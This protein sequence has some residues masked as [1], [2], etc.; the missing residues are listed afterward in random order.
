MKENVPMRYPIR[1]QNR[2]G[3]GFTLVEL[4][5]VIAIIGILIALLLPAVQAARE[6]ARRA[7]CMS[8]MKQLGLAMQTFADGNRGLPPITL[9]TARAS[10]FA[11][12]YPYIE[13]RQLWDL[14]VSTAQ[15][16]TW[17]S[18]DA[19]SWFKLDDA[20]WNGA[21][22]DAQRSG[23]AGVPIYMCPSRRTSQIANTTDYIRGP[24][25]DYAAV[26]RYIY[27]ND[28]TLNP[29]RWVEF[30]TTSQNI[31]RH[32]GALRT[33]VRT[34]GSIQSWR[35][36]DGMER[37]LDGT[38]NTVVFG[39]KHIPSSNV[40]VCGGSS[41]ETWDCSYLCAQ[42][43]YNS[44]SRNFQVGRSIHFVQP[45]PIARGSND[46]ADRTTYPHPGRYNYYAFGSSHPGTCIFALGD[47]SVRGFPT[48]TAREIM[49][50]VAHVSDGQ[51]VSMP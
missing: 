14:I 38:S 15:P 16:T 51:P 44:S 35:P 47:G 23:F 20:W 41:N 46:F 33:S 8:H 37:F 6:A 30:F 11:M 7:Q 50:A 18:N 24:K 40:G 28:Q 25:A 2:R 19:D 43:D 1:C 29:N 27:N 45:E 4:L 34:N 21:L 49:L 42:G 36:R 32:F 22:D 31:D 10:C 12:L 26:I 17:N 9:G 13:Q 3:G 5:V 48:S 39:E